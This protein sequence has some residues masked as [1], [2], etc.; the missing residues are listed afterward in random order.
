MRRIGGFLSAANGHLS[1]AK[2]R[3]RSRAAELQ[4]RSDVFQ[5][6]QHSKEIS[7]DGHL[8][9]GES[10]LPITDPEASRAA[11]VVAGNYVN[12]EAHQFCDV[13]TVG[14]RA[15]DLLRRLLAGLHEK[16]PVADA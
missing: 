1:D 11:R 4:V 13:E 16:I 15:D 14:D 2:S 12:P 3:S 10:Q 5:I 8:R 6:L 7:G 9:N